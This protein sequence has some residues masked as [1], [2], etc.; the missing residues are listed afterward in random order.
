MFL[1]ISWVF[2]GAVIGSVGVAGIA[3]AV[4]SGGPR[5]DPDIGTVLFLLLVTT[6]LGA[7]GGGLFARMVRRKFAGDPRK[8]NLLAG[9][10]L[11][12]AAVLVGYAM[13]KP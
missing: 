1:I 12:A 4:A 9:A 6:V 11:L 3:S 8:L 13:F 5:N 10:P 2:T 7:V